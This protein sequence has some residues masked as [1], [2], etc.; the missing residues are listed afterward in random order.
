MKSILKNWKQLCDYCGEYKEV[1]YADTETGIVCL[2]CCKD[3]L[4]AD[5]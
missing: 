1:Q 3:V 5:I 4:G 2:K